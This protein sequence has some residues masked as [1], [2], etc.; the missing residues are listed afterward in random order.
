[1][2]TSKTP[3]IIPA[4]YR[5][6]SQPLEATVYELTLAALVAGW[7]NEHL[8]DNPH[9]PFSRAAVEIRV[10]DSDQKH[11]LCLYSRDTNLPV[12]TG[13]IKMPGTPLGRHPLNQA[14]VQNALDKAFQTGVKYC[15]TW[16]VRQFVLFDSQ[17]QNTPLAERSIEGP[18]AVV[19]VSDR[20]ELEREGPLRQIRSFWEQFLEDFAN[21]LDDK[22]RLRPPPIDQRFIAWLDGALEDPIAHSA[23][24]LLTKTN[25]DP[26]FRKQMDR[27]VLS[28]GWE[29]STHEDQRTQNFERASKLSCYILVTKLVFYQVLRRRFI[30]MSA[31][32]AEGIE[33][34]NQLKDVL[35]ARFQEAVHY[36]KDYQTIFPRGETDLGHDIPFLTDQ[37]PTDWTRVIER[38]DD[39][40]FSTLDFEVIGQIYERLISTRE[41]RRFGQFYTSPDVVDLINSFCIR[42]PDDLV[43]DPACGGGT[44]LVRAYQRKRALMNAEQETPET[45]ERLLDRIFGIDLA[46]FPAQLSTINLA[47]RHISD[48]GNYPRVAKANFFDAQPGNPLY[49]IPLTGE[50]TRS[51]ALTQV[52]AVVG[53]PPYIRQEAI[54]QGDKARFTHLFRQ[55]WPGRPPLSQR[56]DLYVHFFTHAARLL[57][58]NGYLGFITS[59][60]WLDTAYGSKLQEFLLD[61]FRI[62]AVMESM[63]EK[64][65]EDARVTTAVTILQREEDTAKRDNNTVRFI[66]LRKPL[67]DIYAQLL[68]RPVATHP[69]QGQQDM[70]T[71]RNL[72]ESIQSPVTT[73]YWQVRTR[74]QQSLWAQG[75][76]LDRFDHEE[77]KKHAGEYPRDNAAW[78]IDKP[79]EYTNSKWGQY[80]RGPESWFELLQR[81]QKRMTPLTNL[82]GV[83]R[84]FTSGADSFYCVRDVTEHHLQETPDPDKFKQNWGITKEDTSRVRIV[85]DGQLREHLVEKK[86]LE[87][88]VHSPMDA[89]RAIVRKKDTTRTVINAPYSR[90]RIRDTHFERYVALAEQQGLHTTVTVAARGRNRPWYDLGLRP[91]QQRGPILWPMAQQY[92]HLAPLNPDLL[93]VNHNLFEIYPRDRDKT[94]LLWAMLNSTITALAKHQYGRIAGIEGNLKT[95]VVDVNMMLLPDISNAPAAAAAKAVAACKKLAR[96]DAQRYLHQEFDIEHRMELDDA[97]LEILGIDTPQERHDLRH[98][99]YEDMRQLQNNTKQRETVAQSH[100]RRGN[101]KSVPTAAHLADELWNQYHTTMKLLQFPQDFVERYNNGDIFH[102]PAGEVQVGNALMDMDNMLRAGSLRVGGPQGQVVDA[103]SVSRALFLEALANCHRTGQVRLPPDE[104]CQQAVG[105]FNKYCV[106]IRTNWDQLANE[107]T[108]DPRRSRAITDALMRKTLQWTR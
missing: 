90:A 78:E 95:E 23:D 6:K 35:D 10:A 50:S 56:S 29:P 70:D 91:R 62:I 15:F 71:V 16:N 17:R 3:D 97:I 104:T 2:T 1:M 14:L 87:P 21:L 28:Q 68:G 58:P 27:W 106:N 11:D 51:I 69:V 99:I 66:Q 94:E 92:R 25:L 89:K 8:A 19:N 102:L 55:E 26:A 32:S 60:G 61:N 107:Y 40:D 49:D 38:I 48:Q 59:V 30:Q 98:R 36:S 42:Q 76:G 37:S 53:N 24:A 47:V 65:F 39:F 108:S 13:E 57:K 22:R 74:T 31:L 82:A 103:G 100:R 88:E 81:A 44:F 41:R 79:P 54:P 45:H 96:Q 64:W 105:D 86:F 7:V 9:L 33:S 43:L 34:P 18:T 73:D 83:R 77:D 84:G 20:K 72:I 93:P 46:A 101:R 85:R 63:V 52:D 12:L 5:T 4:A 67:T 80:L 75:T